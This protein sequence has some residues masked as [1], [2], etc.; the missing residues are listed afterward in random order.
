MK[1]KDASN[2]DDVPAEIDF[3]KGVPAHHEERFNLKGIM[4]DRDLLKQF[5]SVEEVEQ[6]LRDFLARKRRV[7][8]TA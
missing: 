1:R 5:D 7:K 8:R 6:A 3:S 2:K 4:L